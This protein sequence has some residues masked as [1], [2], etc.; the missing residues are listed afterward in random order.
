MKKIEIEV[1]EED[2]EVYTRIIEGIQR[3]HAHGNADIEIII[4]DK[5]IISCM[6]GER[7]V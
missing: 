6:F 2:I 3:M 1:K 5:K 7:I 4:R